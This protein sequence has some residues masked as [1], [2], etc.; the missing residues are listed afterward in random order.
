M[1]TEPRHQARY[2]TFLAVL[3]LL[4]ASAGPSRGAIDHQAEEA[5]LKLE[6]VL[7]MADLSLDL[8]PDWDIS[9]TPFALRCPDGYCYLVNHP[10]PPAGFELVR[11]AA[12]IRG[13]TVHRAPLTGAEGEEPYLVSGVP[14]AVIEFHGFCEEALPR[15]FDAAFRA[16]EMTKCPDLTE[17]LTLAMG[18]PTDAEA[19][20]SADIECLLLRGAALAPDDSLTQRVRDFVSVRKQRRLRVGRRYAEYERRIEFAE[21]MARYVAELCRE[22]GSTFLDGASAELLEGAVGETLGLEN[23]LEQ[24]PGP[25]WYREERFRWTG[26][27]ICKVMDRLDPDWKKKVARECTD[28]FELMLRMAKGKTPPPRMVLARYGYEQLVAARVAEIERAKTGF[29]RIFERVTQSTSP[30]FTIDTQQLASGQVRF[31]PSGIER[32]D[33]HREVHTRLFQIEYSGGTYVHVLGRSVALV[34]GEDEFD[35]RKLTLVAP[36]TYSIVLDGEELPPEEGVYQFTRLLSVTGEGFS[37][38]ARAGTVTVG[39]RG[40]SFTLHR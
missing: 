21:G 34:L 17:P 20:V 13:A 36:E 40:V 39:E 19:Q 5:L 12:P 22:T 15:A 3:V 37:M 31:D 8:W 38:E 10:N 9:T 32:V 27:L 1:R 35:F 23:E 18:Y 28:P 14:T 30:L 24:Y 33:E 11:E 16:H 29:L 25:S 7:E 2:P 4:F 6:A 26:A